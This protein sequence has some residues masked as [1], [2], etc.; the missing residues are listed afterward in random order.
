[1]TAMAVV[2][3]TDAAVGLVLAL[4]ALSAAA[5][6][7]YRPA[8]GALTPEIVGEKDLAAANSIFSALENLV[9]VLGPGIGGLLLLTGQPV[10]GVAI[11]AASF[12]I[13]AAMIARLRVRAPAGPQKKAMPCASLR[14]GSRRWVRSPSRWRSSCSV[15]WT[16][17]STGR[18]PSCLPRC[19]SGWARVPAATATCWPG[20]RSAG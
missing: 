13:A 15:P 20:Q 1:M 16:P 14:A 10:I 9:V 19:P 18:A 12:F 2:V 5:L 11:N 17:P 7:P 6:A 3:A 8:A 4:S